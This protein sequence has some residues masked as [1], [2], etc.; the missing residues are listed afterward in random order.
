MQANMQNRLKLKLDQEVTWGEI[1]SSQEQAILNELITLKSKY[2]T[3]S[4]QGETSAQR[5][6]NF[7]N[8]QND[9]KSW[10]QSQNI[11]MSL[12]PGFGRRGMG[13]GLWPNPSPSS[14]T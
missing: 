8:M 12:I 3:G 13:R 4:M 14:S 7:Q 2:L 6:Q 1:T 10:A 9:L 5:K 11:D